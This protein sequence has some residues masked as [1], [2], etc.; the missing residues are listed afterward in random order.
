MAR[1]EW[2]RAAGWW[3][4]AL[5][6]A[7]AVATILLSHLSAPAA[8]VPLTA[9]L[10]PPHGAPTVGQVDF[11]QALGLLLPQLVLPWMALC[12]EDLRPR[13]RAIWAAYPVP[14]WARVVSWLAPAILSV[15]LLSAVLPLAWPA[16]PPVSP[17]AAATLEMPVALVLSGSVF[18]T[19]ELTHSLELG[20]AGAVLLSV[21]SFMAM[22]FVRAPHP[23]WWMLFA[24]THYSAGAALT[25]SRWALGGIGALAWALGTGLYRWRERRG[26]DT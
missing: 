24:A 3:M 20:T 13:G 4:A 26:Q 8:A 25:E 12:L 9:L 22:E 5:A 2:R 23:A 21:A 6:L 16:S 1:A 19:A 10:N 11:A 18:F 17:W 15:V 14:A 7:A